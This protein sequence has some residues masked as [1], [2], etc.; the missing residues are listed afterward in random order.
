MHLMTACHVQATTATLKTMLQH[1]DVHGR[2]TLP[3]PMRYGSTYVYYV[4]TSGLKASDIAGVIN[5]FVFYAYGVKCVVDRSAGAEHAR[6]EGATF[7][8][9]LLNGDDASMFDE[10]GKLDADHT[11]YDS[12]QKTAAF[13]SFK[14]WAFAS[15]WPT[16][17]IDLVMRQVT[18][19]YS[20]GVSDLK[21]SGKIDIQVTT[22]ISLTSLISVV[23]ALHAWHHVF[24]SCAQRY[25]C[26]STRLVADMVTPCMAEMGLDTKPVFYSA[27]LEDSAVH[28]WYLGNF[29]RMSVYP[30]LQHAVRTYGPGVDAVGLHHIDVSLAVVPSI[31][32]MF[33]L[34]KTRFSP[35]HIAGLPDSEYHYGVMLYVNALVKNVRVHPSVPVLGA[36]MAT[37]RRISWE[38]INVRGEAS[39]KR[40][41][42]LRARDVI[43]SYDYKSQ[44]DSRY[45]PEID[46][47]CALEI[48]AANYSCSIAD[49]LEAEEQVSSITHLP[50]Y[51]EAHFYEALF[52]TDYA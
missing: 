15:G 48:I 50:A 35:A 30:V 49:I 17:A 22:G 31:S 47:N 10:E 25:G 14:K 41:R 27:R 16:D 7:V 32:C 5:D 20:A 18:M 44:W 29:C 38:T 12:T 11:Q 9:K 45:A 52:K 4:W 13:S 28:P 39:G 36:L 46:R 6:D 23:N 21:V 2:H 43:E 34:L 51:V 40:K 42:V 26:V 8:L 37:L 24:H 19:N 1:K 33:K 3:E